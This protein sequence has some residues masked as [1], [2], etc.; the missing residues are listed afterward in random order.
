[1]SLDAYL[2][3]YSNVVTQNAKAMKVIAK[4]TSFGNLTLENLS[5]SLNMGMDD[6]MSN[7]DFFNPLIMIEDVSDAASYGLAQM[8][9][10]KELAGLR[11]Y[12]V[13]EMITYETGGLMDPFRK[14][15]KTI[16]D[17]KSRQPKMPDPI[18]GGDPMQE[19]FDR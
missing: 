10:I 17:R 2:R 15:Y 1:M 6:G 12:G 19:F 8:L 9:T 18:G 3:D 7:L 4:D 14:K 11:H 5:S 13:Y 16:R